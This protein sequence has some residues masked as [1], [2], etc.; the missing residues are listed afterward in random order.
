M[1]RRNASPQKMNGS[2][3]LP[4]GL[5]PRS[6][7]MGGSVVVAGTATAA[8]ENRNA[9]IVARYRRE[10]SKSIARS[11]PRGS[12][13]WRCTVQRSIST[14]PHEP[15]R[16]PPVQRLCP[17]PR[18]G[19]RVL[20]PAYGCHMD[21]GRPAHRAGCGRPRPGDD[22][23]TVV[24]MDSVKRSWQR[25]AIP[26]GIQPSDIGRVPHARFRIRKS[27]VFYLMWVAITRPLGVGSRPPFSRAPLGCPRDRPRS[28]RS[29]QGHR[30]PTASAFP[31]QT[32]RLPR[33]LAPSNLQRRA[34]HATQ[35]T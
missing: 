13:S 19:T 1:P 8:E 7:V 31:P 26:C 6:T 10:P 20:G 30:W 28:P 5:V 16:S 9:M 24:H 12:N 29:Q 34:T 3:K 18:K 35:L 14:T 2:P 22:P 25:R 27:P 23:S 15:L 11:P 21:R 4:A 17:T 32:R 33:P